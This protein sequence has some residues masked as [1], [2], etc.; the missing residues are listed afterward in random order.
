MRGAAGGVR[1]D[2]GGTREAGE[3]REEGR[4]GKREER[5]G[6]ESRRGGEKEGERRGGKEERGGR[7]GGGSGGERKGEEDARQLETWNGVEKTRQKPLQRAL[8][9]RRF[10]AGLVATTHANQGSF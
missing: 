1:Q 3:R 2:R 8:P 10:K 9:Q 7:R 6:G 4:G 5:R